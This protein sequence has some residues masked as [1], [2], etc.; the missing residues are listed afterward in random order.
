MSRIKT[1]EELYQAM[2]LDGK[3][4]VENLERAF[5]DIADALINDFAILKNKKIYHFVEMEFY[6]NLIDDTIVYPR[7]AD[8]LC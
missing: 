8:A 4:S 3:E 2:R 7:K 1:T 5:A 6:H